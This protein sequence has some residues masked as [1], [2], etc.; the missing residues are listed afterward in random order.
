MEIRRT[1]S[2]FSSEC[3]RKSASKV[4]PLIN[5][6]LASTR[7]FKF[8]AVKRVQNMKNFGINIHP[9]IIADYKK[10]ISL[11]HWLFP[12]CFVETTEKDDELWIYNKKLRR[13]QV[14]SNGN[15][16]PFL[17]FSSRFVDFDF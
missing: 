2:L 1:F 3:G 14:E 13:S 8:H 11:I 4:N 15:Q 6:F 5:F 9:G 7:N 16:N 12:V 17:I 10:N